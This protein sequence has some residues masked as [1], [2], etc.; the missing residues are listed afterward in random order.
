M[1]GKEDGDNKTFSLKV[2]QKQYTVQKIVSEA[3]A[4]EHNRSIVCAKDALLALRRQI[5]GGH[6]DGSMHWQT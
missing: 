5:R 6:V 2:I 1:S 3:Q 4:T